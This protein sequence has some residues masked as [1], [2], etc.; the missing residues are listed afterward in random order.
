MSNGFDVS[1]I[2]FDANGEII[3]LADE[4]LASISAGV[5]NEEGMTSATVNVVGCNSSCG[6]PNSN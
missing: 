6:K 5:K 1:S 2:T 4:V 3:G